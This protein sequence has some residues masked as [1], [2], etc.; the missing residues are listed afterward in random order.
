[1]D[2]KKTWITMLLFLLVS[3]LIWVGFSVYFSLSKEDV[4]PN[5]QTYTQPLSVKFDTQILDKVIE[6]VKELPIGTDTFFNLIKEEP[7]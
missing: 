7:N 2:F 4:N 6:R 5:A 3:V 1:M